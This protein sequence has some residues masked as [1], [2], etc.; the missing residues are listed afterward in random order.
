MHRL[1]L[2]IIIFTFHLSLSVSV[3][4]QTQ[5]MSSYVRQIYMEHVARQ[6]CGVMSKSVGNM[7]S[8]P[9]MPVF[10]KVRDKEVL[11]SNGFMILAEFGD[12]YVVSSPVSRLESLASLE[13][14]ERVEAGRPCEITNND[15]AAMTHADILHSGSPDYTGKGVVVG[16]MD[17]GMDLTHPTFWSADGSTYRIKSYWDMLDQTTN[18]EPV[19]GVDT[20]Y[21]GRQ[22][23]TESEILA[24]GCSTDGH[25]TG[26]GT[27]TTGTA[28]GSGRNEDGT[29]S[30][31]AGMAPDADMCLVSNYTGS[32]KSVVPE[33]ERYKYNT[34]LDAV[35]F[36]YI[37][38]Y[39]QSQNKPC[40][41]SFS[42]GSA[43]EMEGSGVLFNE[44]LT[45]MQGPGRILVSSAG[46]E[47]D[48]LTYIN[49]GKGTATAGAFVKP[50]GTGAYYNMRSSDKMTLRITYYPKGKAPLI[51]EYSTDQIL[52]C[53]KS[54][55][56]DTFDIGT[57]KEV[58]LLNAYPNVYEESTWATELYLTIAD[59]EETIAKDIPIS[60]TLLGED[61]SVEAFSR[62]GYF[63]TNSL[64]VSLNDADNTHN[65][66]M[67]G[68]LEAAICVGATVKSTVSPTIANYS[69]IGPSLA[70]LTKPDV[71]APGN[72]ITSARSKACYGSY[73]WRVAGGTSMATPVVGGIVALWLQ[74]C[75]TLTREQ[76]LEAIAATSS[77]PDMSLDYPNNT[78]GYGFIDA[79]A[80]LQYVLDNYTGIEPPSDSPPQGE[81][82]AYYDLQG[83]KLSGP[84]SSK[85]IY[86]KNRHKIIF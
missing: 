47:A 85:G 86:I 31:Y 83:R 73:G 53:E 75:P 84:P 32:V 71:V 56:A 21:V 48:K 10:V 82:P 11:R 52:P 5:K 6:R 20:T 64:D 17:I 24:K 69:G 34:A 30:L 78:Y 14:V 43:Q 50:T 57:T 80:G 7:V 23:T 68:A 55:L 13:G 77:H 29:L 15:A 9:S 39:A 42:E 63:S 40:V 74:A 67:P 62:G 44:A 59:S 66:L 36:K 72:G 8:S 25:L 70:G 79:E 12:V 49:K 51:K 46:N 65:V 33:K 1:L 38:D 81:S 76:A 37:F 54:I 18:G 35:G 3:K 19:E 58:V 4:A 45:H 2:I 16:V 60:I 26:H 61:I 28:A 41:I 27:H 22:Y